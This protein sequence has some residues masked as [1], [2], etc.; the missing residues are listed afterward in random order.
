MVCRPRVE[1]CLL[2]GERYGSDPWT[3]TH[4]DEG[5]E[6]HGLSLSLVVAA[7]SPVTQGPR[8]LTQSSKRSRAACSSWGGLAEERLRLVLQALVDGNHKLL[9]DVIAGASRIDEPQWG[10]RPG[11]TRPH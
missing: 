1:C 6:F 7:S 10:G 5:Y 11:V 3:A 9:V 4:R 2:D 8:N